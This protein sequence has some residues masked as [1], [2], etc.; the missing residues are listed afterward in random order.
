MTNIEKQQ[1]GSLPVVPGLNTKRCAYRKYNVS[2]IKDQKCVVPVVAYS[3]G[4]SQERSDSLATYM[5]LPKVDT[6]ANRMAARPMDK[7]ELKEWTLNIYS[8]YI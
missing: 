7:V 8:G 6:V 3:S 1:S 5:A 4:Q 2:K